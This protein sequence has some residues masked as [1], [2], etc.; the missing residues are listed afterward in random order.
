[1]ALGGTFGLCLGANDADRDAGARLA[2]GLAAA[3]PVLRLPAS[4]GLPCPPARGCLVLDRTV[5]PC[6]WHLPF[7]LG[8]LAPSAG[9]VGVALLRRHQDISGTLRACRRAGTGCRPRWGRA[10]CSRR[11]A[12]DTR[13]RHIHLAGSIRQLEDVA[14]E[15]PYGWHGWHGIGRLTASGRTRRERSRSPLA[16]VIFLL[17]MLH[18]SAGRSFRIACVAAYSFRPRCFFR[19]SR[20]VTGRLVR[21]GDQPCCP[22]A[23]C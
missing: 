22:P 14:S 17:P 13:Y 8:R 7:A 11:D 15:Q 4:L 12:T 21:M 16:L 5:P 2:A 3:Q 9:Y 10:R 1:M 23:P 6:R 19:P 18:K 20:Y